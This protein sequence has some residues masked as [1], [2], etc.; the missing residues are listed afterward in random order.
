V[1]VNGRKILRLDY[2][3]LGLMMHSVGESQ[4]T[5]LDPTEDQRLRSRCWVEVV[6]PK[7][8]GHLYST[9]DVA[10]TYKCGDENFM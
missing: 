9:G 8:K 3:K 6:G 7:H 4:I 1:F 5:P 2:L 10:H